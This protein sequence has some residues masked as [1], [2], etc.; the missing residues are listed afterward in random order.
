MRGTAEGGSAAILQ[1]CSRW[2]AGYAIP[3]DFL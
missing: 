1:V 2:N 3:Y